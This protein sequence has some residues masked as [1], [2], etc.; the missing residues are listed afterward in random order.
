MS[1]SYDRRQGSSP[2]DPTAASPNLAESKGHVKIVIKILQDAVTLMDHP[3]PAHGL[4]PEE[5]LSNMMVSSIELLTAI[6]KRLPK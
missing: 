2:N 1:Y 3:Q 5:M 4:T 6:H